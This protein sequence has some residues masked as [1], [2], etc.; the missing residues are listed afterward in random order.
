M[1]LC[2]GAGC[3]SK[4]IIEYDSTWFSNSFSLRTTMHIHIARIWNDY[5][6]VGKLEV[7]RNEQISYS[8]H[9]ILTPDPNDK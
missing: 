7:Y 1:L 3:G 2:L 6:N 5:V 9:I 8:S 4:Q